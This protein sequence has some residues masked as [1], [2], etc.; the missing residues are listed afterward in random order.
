[1]VCTRQASLSIGFSRQEYWSGL[2]CPPSGD[3]PDPGINLSLLCLLHWQTGSLPLALPGKP[4]QHSKS[5]QNIMEG[6]FPGG[7]VVKTLP[8]NAQGVGSI[9]GWEAKILQALRPK[10]QSIKQKQY[11]NKFNK[12]FKNGPCQ[13]NL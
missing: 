8:F 3:L 10:H 7:P 4:R 1:M 9:P 13:K 2:A 12:D 5:L 11:Y 6:T